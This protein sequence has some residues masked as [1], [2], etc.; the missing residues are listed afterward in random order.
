MTC[1]E[2]VILFE[3]QSRK[4]FR[5]AQD[6][7]AEAVAWATA[8]INKE[9]YRMNAFGFFAGKVPLMAMVG[10]LICMNQNLS[11]EEIECELREYVGVN[12]EKVV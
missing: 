8:L 2:V 9:A 11:D 5:D 3:E 1:E 6:V 12:I 10:E 7:V 4:R